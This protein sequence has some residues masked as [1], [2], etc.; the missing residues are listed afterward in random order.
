MI[1]FKGLKSKIA[2]INQNHRKGMDRKRWP[3]RVRI[4]KTY[5]TFTSFWKVEG[6]NSVILEESGTLLCTACAIDADLGKGEIYSSVSF[7]PSICENCGV[8][9]PTKG[10]IKKLKKLLKTFS[11]RDM[12]KAIGMAEKG[13]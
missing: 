13:S 11:V 5:G 1:G 3:F 9:F 7:A 12:L 10:M 4:A 2:R 8:E 6:F